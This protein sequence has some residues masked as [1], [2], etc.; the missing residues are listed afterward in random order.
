MMWIN[1]LYYALLKAS[2]NANKKNYARIHGHHSAV[3]PARAGTTIVVVESHSISNREL[4][5]SHREDQLDH[6]VDSS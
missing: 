3:I 5:T 2:T 6:S 4:P 1:I